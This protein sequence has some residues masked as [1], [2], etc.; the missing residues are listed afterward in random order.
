[1]SR[2]SPQ[3]LATQL[4]FLALWLLFLL[5]PMVF[6]PSA[7]ESFRLPKLLLAEGLALLSLVCL[8]FRLRHLE[9]V[10]LSAFFRQPV[11]VAILPI[12]A[13]AT[14]GLL[15]SDH[16]LHVRQALASLWIGLACL[17][18]WSSLLSAEEHWT[19]LRSLIFPATVLSLL[20]LLQFYH[21]FNPFEFA[22]PVEARLGITSLAGGAFD[23]AAYLVLPCILVQVSLWRQPAGASRWVEG[24][25][26]LASFY[27]LA[28]TQT[29]TAI[30]A[31][32]V[33]T[34]TLWLV[35][36]PRRRA[37]LA[38]AGVAL[39][40]LVVG[41]AIEPLRERLDRKLNSLQRG[42]IDR[43]L[44]G[45]LDGWRAALWMWQEHPWTGVGH[46]AY[47]AEFGFA[48]EA[49]AGEGVKFYRSQ[50][51]VYFVNAH[52]D[53]LEALAEWGLLGVVAVAWGFHV[54]LRALRRVAAAGGR[55]AVGPMLAGLAAVAVLASSNFPLRIGLVAYPVLFFLSW[56]FASSR[57]AEQ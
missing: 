32:M 6:A 25:A 19:L 35:L 55:S 18:A 13:V 5:V 44:T 57:E 43:V 38:A 1:M 23:L 7:Q 45:R 33:G 47:R 26:A 14:S 11:V 29:L 48:K 46:G 30:V 3:S 40:L 17:V 52:S 20:A 50:H 22:D 41:L 54:L 56:I 42:D 37:M 28:V 39:A 53:P 2:S 12:L 34:V 49:L 27:A 24:L 15:T 36:L 51:Q 10:D 31:V 9:R 4:G 21:F 8:V 16:P